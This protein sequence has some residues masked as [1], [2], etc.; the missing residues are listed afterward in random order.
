MAR[1]RPESAGVDSPTSPR[2]VHSCRGDR[3]G[4][5]SRFGTTIAGVANAA[6][7]KL[8]W[9]D[10]RVFLAAARAGSL[11]GAARARGVEHSTIGR[12]LK[13]LEES[14]GVALFTRNA[15]GL[16]LTPLGA[17]VVPL[18]EQMER[19]A[20]A[21]GEL[22]LSRKIR[23][24]VA[25]PSGF[26]R[27][28]GPR[29]VDFHRSFPGLILEIT[30]GSRKVDLKRGDADLAIR[31]GGSDD[32]ELVSRKVGEVG[33]SLYASQAYLARHPGP[34]DPRDLAGHD[35]LGYEAAL[36]SMPAARWLDQQAARAN[37]VMRSGEASDLVDACAA[38]LGLAVLP[39][40]LAATEPALVRLTPEI[41]HSGRLSLVYRKE[42]LVAAHVQ[43]V[44]T[45]LT[46]VMTEYADRLAGRV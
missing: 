20:Q 46:D 12:R 40:G 5:S 1:V 42:V 19:A 7:D 10:L 33:W 45:F 32:E 44:I 21:I 30:S 35:L 31:L 2:A 3:A 41:L 27:I 13:A 39:C 17:Q 37:V 9:N 28:L 8:D 26:S 11:A 29:L 36:A 4:R 16:L 14:L 43:P 38:G 25:T 34:T 6:D 18:L 23:V 15:D 22:A 24:R